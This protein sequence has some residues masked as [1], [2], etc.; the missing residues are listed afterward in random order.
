[1]RENLTGQISRKA[2]GTDGVVK[3]TDVVQGPETQRAVAE[4]R[5]E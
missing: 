2:E 3:L 5:A 4:I 1:M